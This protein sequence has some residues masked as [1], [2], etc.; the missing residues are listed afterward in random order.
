MIFQA[1][2]EKAHRK[3]KS[4]YISDDID[5]SEKEFY[6]PMPPTNYIMNQYS[7]LSCVSHAVAMA[8]MVAINM[9]TNKWIKLSPFSLHGYNDNKGG[10]TLTWY[11]CEA[12]CR[13]GILPARVFS[14]RG[15]NPKLHKILVSFINKNP[16]ATKI[17]NMYKGVA[18]AELSSFDDIKR[19]LKAGYPVVGAVKVSK[20]FGKI[21]GGYEPIYPKGADYYHEIEFNGWC[22]KDGKEYLTT[23]NSHGKFSGENGVVRI[24]RG[25]LIKDI[26]L[27]DFNADHFKKKAKKIEFYIGATRFKVDGELKDFEASPYI[28]NNRTYLPV[29]FVAENLGAEVKW[30]ANNGTA[31]IESEEALITISTNSKVIII[32]GKSKKMDV[33]PEIVNGRMMCPI[34][35]IA[36]ALNCKVEWSV[37]E[38]KVVI[39]A[40]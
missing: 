38:N 23:I 34:R 26:A 10:G 12:L 20:S 21:N 18:Y 1:I 37:S 39:T 25:R 29:R 36:E 30:D 5:I 15:D 31:T 24:P 14:A 4:F 13:F 3:E 6:L 11:I 35:H 8:V 40:L 32:D 22:E 9:Q 17:A 7:S 2:T 28:K 19:A 16:L 27:I 33:M